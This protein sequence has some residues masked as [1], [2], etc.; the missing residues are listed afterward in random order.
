M[1]N[2]DSDD[3]LKSVMSGFFSHN[4]FNSNNAKSNPPIVDKKNEPTDVTSS[5]TNTSE[6]NV[7]INS[8]LRQ[9]YRPESLKEPFFTINS[10]T[11]TNHKD[12][13]NVKSKHMRPSNMAQIV[14]NTSPVGYGGSLTPLSEQP[15]IGQLRSVTV[16]PY[17]KPSD[18]SSPSGPLDGPSVGS[19]TA[20]SVPSVGPSAGP[21]AG[22]S[23]GSS[24]PSVGPSV[25]LLD[26]EG[27]VAIRFNND[28]AYFTLIN[29]RLPVTAIQ[30]RF[31]LPYI[32]INSVVVS[33]DEH[34]LSHLY[35][36]S[37]SELTIGQ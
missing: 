5:N 11:P 28:M 33:Y 10:T 27:I 37:G 21:S 12:V 14:C 30:N 20:P 4:G 18:S 8:M 2:T 7:S 22:S 26:S 16:S 15:P 13:V 29:R 24:V 34:G 35:F 23:V 31:M 25:S 19:S 3:L 1:N 6:P 36:N 9:R 32:T 17:H